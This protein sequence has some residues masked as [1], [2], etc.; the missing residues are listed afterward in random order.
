MASSTNLPGIYV[1]IKGDYSKLQK[2]IKQAKQIVSSEALNISNALNNALSPSKI[3][4]S[5]NSLVGNFGTLNRASSVA[6][7]VF[8]KI[9]VDLKGLNSITGLTEKELGSL[10]SRLLQTQAAN[11][12][13]NSLRNIATACNLSEK[14][15]RKLG[16]QFGLSSTQIAKVTMASKSAERSLFSLSNVTK[17]AMAYLTV[18]SAASSIGNLIRIADTYTLLE[19]RLRL[20]TDSEEQLKQTEKSLFEIAQE[21]RG[22]YEGL[23]DIYARFARATKDAKIPQS[24]LLDIVKGVNQA[25]IVSGST[26]QESAAAMIQLSQG[27][28]SG[29]LRG[30]E[31][32]SVLEQTPRVARMI[33]DGLG[34]TIGKLREYG[35]EGKLSTD[36]I[37]NALLS[38]AKGVNAEFSTMETTVGQAATVF[39]NTFHD[40]VADGNKVTGSTKSLAGSIIDLSNTIHSHK[41][42]IIDLFSGAAEAAGWAT[43]RVANFV[44]AVKGVSAVAAGVLDLTDF[45]TM[46]P[47]ELKQWMTDFDNGTAEIKKKLKETREELASLSDSTPGVAPK[48]AALNKQVRDLEGQL[49]AAEEAQ[50]KLGDSAQATGSQLDKATTATIK[51]GNAKK[52]ASAASKIHRAELRQTVA[53]ARNLVGAYKESTSVLEKWVSV[54]SDSRIDMQSLTLDYSITGQGEVARLLADRNREFAEGREVINQYNTALAESGQIV[55]KAQT[56]LT[57]AQQDFSAMQKELAANPLLSSAEQQNRLTPFADALKEKAEATRVALAEQMKLNELNISGALT[58]EALKTSIFGTARA[59]EELTAAKISDLESSTLFSD[60]VTAGLMRVSVEA[61]RAGA[62]ISDSIVDGFDTAADALADFVTTGKIEFS[63]MVESI[64]KDIARLTI[65]Q[66]I[67]SPSAGA[68]STALGSLS[69]NAQGGVYTSPSLSSYSNGVYDTPKLFAFATGAGVFAES[70]PEAI[71]PLTRTNNGDLGVKA[72]MA[73]PTINVTVNNAPAGTTAKVTQSADGMNI[74]VIVDALERRQQD[75]LNRGYN[76]VGRTSPW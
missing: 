25:L 2:D 58:E 17:G 34:V 24:D 57:R 23:V 36:V 10:Q 6:H 55:S 52:S 59:L 68:L 37:L 62:S 48:M 70:G 5:I 13:V 31:L 1:E 65:Q 54:A 40:L 38:Q 75:R 72:Q 22:S 30:E 42:E 3:T 71:M 69:A 50:K 12:Q 14:E 43:E 21:T 44:N 46:N 20:V 53:E 18:S 27:L 39:R 7:E 66:T 49:K 33:A 15:I 64:L 11:S 28:A 47:K 41:T 9:G 29:A 74:D 56:E 8:E 51:L 73:S 16:Q 4:S 61:N 76:G 32:N 45:A 63:G 67:T 19:G 60:N 26:Q 35:K